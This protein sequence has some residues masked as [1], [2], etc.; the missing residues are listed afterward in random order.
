MEP[1][2]AKLFQL[3]P[4]LCNPMDCS[5]P[6]SLVHGILQARLVKWVD[7]PRCCQQFKRN[8]YLTKEFL[9]FRCENG[10]DLARA[11]VMYGEWSHF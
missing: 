4:T 2:H 9:T 5:P 10:K 8:W 7:L 1:M 6:G 11:L 3:S